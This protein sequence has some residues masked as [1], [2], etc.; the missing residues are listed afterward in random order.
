[1][2]NITLGII[3]F[4][5]LVGLCNLNFLEPIVPGIYLAEEELENEIQ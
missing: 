5:L 3:L 1:M 2:N 4:I